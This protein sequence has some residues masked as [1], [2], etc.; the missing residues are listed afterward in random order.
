MK[1][2]FW[3]PNS[4]SLSKGILLCMSTEHQDHNIKM[5]GPGVLSILSKW[6]RLKKKEVVFKPR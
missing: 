2:E 3:R 5:L 1:E 4:D 6:F